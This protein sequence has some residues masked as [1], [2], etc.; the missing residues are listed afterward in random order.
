MQVAGAEV[1]VCDIIRRLGDAI[2]PVVFCLDAIG[3]LGLELQREGVPVVAFDRKPGLDWRLVPRMARAIRDY[4][5]DVIHAHQYTPFFYSALGAQLSGRR[6]RVILTEHGR[7]YPDVVSSKRRMANQLVFDRLA[8]H[9]TAVCEFSVRGLAD[10]DG[11]SRSRIE[12]VPNGIEIDRYDSVDDRVALRERL[13]LDVDRL[14]LITVARFHPVKDHATLLRAFERVARARADVDLLLAGDGPKRDEI[15]AQIKGASLEGR[16]RLLGV[17]SD[18][19]DLLR[20]SD[21]FVL[22][23]VSEAASITLLEAMAS[24][25][26]SVVT[27]V[28]G[29][30]ELVRRDIDG[31]LV[32]RGDDAAMARA[33]MQLL[34]NEAVRRTMGAAAAARVRREFRIDQT[35]DAYARLYRANQR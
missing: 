12:V 8:H 19:A 2:R 21:V 11:F 20:A 35:I 10:V 33:M 16:V 31:L 4:G 32:P 24:G 13:G 1:L 15:E 27:D 30:P 28:G 9:M 6:P 18:V 22:S 34:E 26:P 23:S 7:H 25:L 3:P 17:R 5:V 29:N 14:Y